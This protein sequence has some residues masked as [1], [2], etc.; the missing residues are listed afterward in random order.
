MW[1]EQEKREPTWRLNELM[2][3]FHLV[4]PTRLNQVTVFAPV[5]SFSVNK[6][7][8]SSVSRLV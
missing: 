7:M 1:E 2:S 3:S 6:T 5:P 8:V 4:L